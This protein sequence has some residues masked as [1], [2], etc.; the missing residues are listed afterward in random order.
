MS[1][2]II[3]ILNFFVIFT[4]MK[5]TGWLLVQGTRPN[6]SEFLFQS[7]LLSARIFKQTHFH[8]DNL[9]II[10]LKFLLSILY[11][12]LIIWIA[13]HLLQPLTYWKIVLIAPII[14]IFTEFMGAFG[15]LIFYPSKKGVAP[16]H[17]H[18][19]RSKNLGEFWGKRWNFWVR[20]WLRDV[21]QFQRRNQVKK[22]LVTFFVSGF[23]HEL[24]VNLP[25]FL[26]Y[27]ESF[28]GNM[29]LYFAIQGLGLWIEKKFLM[30]APT[31]MR[32]IFMWMVVILPSPLFLN[33]PLLLFF[34]IIDG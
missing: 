20:D 8:K 14:Y 28:F 5:I 26:V 10:L 4:M 33:R 15:Q 25:Y 22:L 30:K 24:L 21:S 18:P 3:F 32:T 29:T 23:F 19:L 12:A 11:L 6:L 1:Y 31:L 2:Q 27:R 9:R 16:I 13:R 34:G 17:L 7:P